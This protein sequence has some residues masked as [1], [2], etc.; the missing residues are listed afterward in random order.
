[1][2]AHSQAEAITVD[3]VRHSPLFTDWCKAVGAQKESL[4]L[5][6]PDRI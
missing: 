6:K 3:F 1:M 2:G 4:S 5:Q